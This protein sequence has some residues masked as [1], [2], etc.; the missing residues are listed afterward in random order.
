M[1]GGDGALFR[2][3]P[4]GEVSALLPA[5]GEV[6]TGLA[7]GDDGTGYVTASGD[8][9]LAIH[10]RPPARPQPISSTTFPSTSLPTTYS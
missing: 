5:T 8:R 4:D 1:R 2:I 10:S 3:A 7:V 9:V 6:P